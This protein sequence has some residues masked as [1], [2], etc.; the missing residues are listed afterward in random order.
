[1]GRAR[2]NVKRTEARYAHLP[3][4]QRSVVVELA[5]V[6]A[7]LQHD[8]WSGETYHASSLRFE[9]LAKLREKDL[10]KLSNSEIGRL[11]FCVMTTIGSRQTVKFLLPRFFAAYFA[12]PEDGWIAEPL[13]IVDRLE[14]ADF[15]SWPENER[16]PV[17]RAL[18]LAAQY[19]IDSEYSL[20]DN[21][22]AR[23]WAQT[24]L[25]GLS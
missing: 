2:K 22:E 18:V 3:E 13:V 17:L 24:R 5:T 23:K 6:F 1:M 8:M 19:E 25:D 15:D 12:A 14:R 11:M 20:D 4:P 9:E 7:S 16:R 10:D 21:L